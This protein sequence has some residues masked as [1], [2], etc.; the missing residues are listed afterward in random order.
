ML[1]YIS[2][3]HFIF[4]FVKKM[5]SFLRLWFFLF[6]V[7]VAAPGWPVPKYQG[8]KGIPCVY[9]E[10]QNVCIYNLFGTQ[11]DFIH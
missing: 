3:V 5:D 1:L 8:K 6:S 11:Y 9:L 2:L 7:F 10:G 4:I